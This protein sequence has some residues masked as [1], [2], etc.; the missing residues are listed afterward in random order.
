MQITQK[1]YDTLPD[2][3]KALFRKLLNHGSEEV[4]AAFP[5]APGQQ[6]DLNGHSKDRL[7]KG[8]FGDMKAARDAVARL[9]SGSAARFF[10]CA[11][12][13]QEDR[14]EGLEDF[15]IQSAGTVT[16]RVDGSAGLNSP[17]AGAGRT[18]GSRNFHP[19]IKPTD[20]MRYLCRLITPPNGLVLDPFAGSGSTGKAARAEGFRFIGIEINEEYCA[21]AAARCEISQR[22]LFG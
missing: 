1:T 9:D 16:D 19:T 3:L 10:Y 2:H 5:D 18:N 14:N 15:P 22:S 6:G 7:S 8:I 17:R 13:S 12:A 21:L 20:L 11:K 4:L